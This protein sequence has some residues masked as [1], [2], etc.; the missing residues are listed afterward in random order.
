[1]APS[2]ASAVRASGRRRARRSAPP[3]RHRQQAEE[4]EQ[5][6]PDRA[7]ERRHRQEGPRGTSACPAGS[8]TRCGRAVS[9]GPGRPRGS[10]GAEEAIAARE[11][12]GPVG[13]RGAARAGAVGEE[14]AEDVSG[15]GGRDGAQASSPCER[16]TPR[17]SASPRSAPHAGGLGTISANTPS[18]PSF[19]TSV[20][21]ASPSRPVPRVEMR[22]P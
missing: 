16:R 8:E 12:R 5:G 4:R 7:A 6:G 2:S 21:I 1:M 19:V 13:A 17:T 18:A 11:G 3:S 20:V 10:R 9:A 22:R 14:R 15:G